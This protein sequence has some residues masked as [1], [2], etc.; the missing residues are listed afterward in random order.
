[1]TVPNWLPGESGP[2]DIRAV[3]WDEDWERSGADDCDEDW[4][5]RLD[6]NPFDHI[7][8]DDAGLDDDDEEP[9]VAR[10]DFWPQREDEE[11]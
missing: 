7:P 6:P 8:W 5:E 10:G 9:Q 3:D 4:D 2:S 1:M 11:T